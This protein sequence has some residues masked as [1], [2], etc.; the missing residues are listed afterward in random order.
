MIFKKKVLFCFEFNLLI[1]YYF[2]YVIFFVLFICWSIILL[3]IY[4]VYC[5]NLIYC[6]CKFVNWFN[7]LDIDI[8]Y[9]CFEKKELKLYIYYKEVLFVLCKMYLVKKK[10][11]IMIF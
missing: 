8:F 2:K 3:D 1:I 6:I 10:K 4:L 9:I 7:I 11:Y 5:V